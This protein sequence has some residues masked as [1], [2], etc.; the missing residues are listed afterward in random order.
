MLGPSGLAA[1]F[2]TL[3]QGQPNA[4]ETF[5]ID[6]A[7]GS[8]ASIAGQIAKLQGA[9]VIGIAGGEGQIRYIR[10]E[11]GFDEAVD[12]MAGEN[13]AEAL[14]AV[15]P[16]GI[17]VFLD[18]VG[19][20]IHDSVMKHIN[21]GVR[22]VLI[23]TISNYNLG[24]GEVD[25]GPRHLYTWIM[26]RARISGFLVGDYAS[27]FDDALQVLSGWLREGKIKYRETIF[28]GLSNCP[29]AFAGLFGAAHVGK[30]LVKV[31]SEG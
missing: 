26:K 15:C 28:D 27:E 13:L 25:S 7:S 21:I 6:A 3:R 5:V 23:G 31:I 19:G 30:M 11:L 29:K 17:D 9:R 2:A 10:D 16:D 22:I 14:G 18:L 8:V 12:Y 24:A 20:E 4:G 1:Y